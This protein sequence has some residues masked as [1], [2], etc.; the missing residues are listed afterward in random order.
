M[1]SN[2]RC[3]ALEQLPVVHPENPTPGITIAELTGLLQI[4]T[5][6]PRT[7][8]FAQLVSSTG[9]DPPRGLALSTVHPVEPGSQRSRQ[10]TKQGKPN[11][12]H[13]FFGGCGAKWIA[14]V[15]APWWPFPS[16]RPRQTCSQ[17]MS[18]AG[19]LTRC[20]ALA[21]NHARSTPECFRGWPP[22]RPRNSRSAAG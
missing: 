16:A 15:E 14:I 2:V 20:S 19:T 5:Q 18:L 21:E 9:T 3:Q 12:C 17:A 7:Q 6:L 11:S 10:D 13:S 4:P 1:A 22:C 8:R